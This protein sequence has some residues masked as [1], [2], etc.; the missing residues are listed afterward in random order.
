METFPIHGQLVGANDVSNHIPDDKA[1]NAN[2]RHGAHSKYPLDA[3]LVAEP[4]V[5]VVDP[6]RG[7]ASFWIV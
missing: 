6:E 1:E 4:N 2:G 3:K 7:R 5:L